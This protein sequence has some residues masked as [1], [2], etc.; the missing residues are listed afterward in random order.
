MFCTW[1]CIALIVCWI[2]CLDTS[3]G[4]REMDQINK[5]SQLH[6]VKRSYSPGIR[7]KGWLADGVKQVNQYDFTSLDC[8]ATS[9]PYPNYYWKKNGQN[10]TQQ[11]NVDLQGSI[12]QFNNG[13]SNRFSTY[14]TS[15]TLYINCV[16]LADAGNYTCVAEVGTSKRERKIELK[17]DAV[18]NPSNATTTQCAQKDNIVDIYM[19][20]ESAV[21][22]S[23]N[24]VR[25]FCRASGTP[26]PSYSWK[27]AN[28]NT[29]IEN[30][31][32]YE[33][34]QEGDLIIK[35]IHSSDPRF[36]KCNASNTVGHDE[37]STHFSIL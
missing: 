14:V 20:T 5:R 17:V 2:H 29:I 36:Y 12:S 37:Y 19:E 10:I 25:L 27:N 28:N 21:E 35:S 9:V 18:A 13:S 26:A 33:I 34:T 1:Y 16:T 6:R 32:K 8:K 11:G 3:N 15:S 4:L 23:G 22:N 7:S 31:Y 30:S 24:D